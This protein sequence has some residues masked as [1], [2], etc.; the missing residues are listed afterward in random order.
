MN[1]YQFIIGVDP[2]VESRALAI[3][4]ATERLKEYVKD[5]HVWGITT[6]DEDINDG[7]PTGV[8]LDFET[9]QNFSTSDPAEYDDL[10]DQFEHVESIDVIPVT[11]IE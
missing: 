9:E 10:L 8:A 3:A 2:D 5:A 7:V 1:N 11:P 6:Y 4:N